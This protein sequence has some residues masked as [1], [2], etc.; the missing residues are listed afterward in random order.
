MAIVEDRANSC[1]VDCEEKAA[2]ASLVL[3][4]GI[5]RRPEEGGHF[6]I[7]RKNGWR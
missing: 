4:I 2:G 7:L 3:R 6:V 5:A 1:G